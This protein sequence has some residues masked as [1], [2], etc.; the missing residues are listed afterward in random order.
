MPDF[1]TRR[2]P[3][4]PDRPSRLDMFVAA[5]KQHISAVGRWK[6]RTM[7]RHWRLGLSVSFLALL[8]GTLTAWAV[9][10]HS[11]QVD[12]ELDWAVETPSEQL[13]QEI[14]TPPTPYYGVYYEVSTLSSGSS[15]DPECDLSSVGD[16]EDSSEDYSYEDSSEDYSC[17]T[18]ITKATDPV[19]LAS[20]TQEVASDPNSGTDAASYYVWVAQVEF[21]KR[22]AAQSHAISYCFRTKGPALAALRR[23]NSRKP[24]LVGQTDD[25]YVIVY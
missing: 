5:S 7:L 14:K 6:D 3:L 25:C 4:D 15:A 22:E 12:E 8:A 17:L 18:V 20:I 24:E 13:R 10:T 1:D 11:E 9:E 16:Y 2:P 21:D 23:S 19:E